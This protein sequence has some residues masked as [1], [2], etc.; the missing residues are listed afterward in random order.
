MVDAD[1]CDSAVSKLQHDIL[2]K[3]EKWIVDAEAQS[4]VRQMIE[5]YLECTSCGNNSENPH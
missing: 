2:D 5:D 1:D 3:V 4:T